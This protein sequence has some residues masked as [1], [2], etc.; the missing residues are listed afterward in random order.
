MKK[1]LEELRAALTAWRLQWGDPAVNQA[2]ADVRHA[3]DAVLAAAQPEPSEEVETLR[4]ECETWRAN[5]QTLVRYDDSSALEWTSMA[6]G[7]YAGIEKH[8]DG[9]P[10]WVDLRRNGVTVRYNHHDHAIESMRELCAARA[11]LTSSPTCAATS[12]A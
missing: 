12:A 3:C 10:V 9:M 1:E 4:S 8:A 2:A 11:L 7:A 6:G 5:A